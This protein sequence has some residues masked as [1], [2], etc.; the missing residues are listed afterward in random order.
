MNENARKVGMLEPAAIAALTETSRE[1]VMA[2]A[3]SG[4]VVPVVG[5][6]DA[7]RAILEDA[8]EVQ[9]AL[10]GRILEFS[11]G[12]HDRRGIF[13]RL[14]RIQRAARGM[15]V[16][17]QAPTGSPAREITEGY[18]GDILEQIDELE[19]LLH[20]VAC[21]AVDCAVTDN[22]LRVIG[23]A[24]ESLAGRINSYL[25]VKAAVS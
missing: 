15:L 4:R 5:E 10:G 9:L 14:H 17:G 8:V 2:A 20:G 24:A 22:N 16:P 3:R 19:N 1:T 7:A 12:D 21:E 6:G 13:D 18:R 23:L 11:P 25:S